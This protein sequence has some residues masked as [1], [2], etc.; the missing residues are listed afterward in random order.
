MEEKQVC[1]S[2][3]DGYG[4]AYLDICKPSVYVK[5]QATRAKVAP[6][7]LIYGSHFSAREATYE[8]SQN[9]E[10]FVESLYL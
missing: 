7:N 10:N 8:M 3:C 6:E 9:M 2:C 5:L 4:N 1:N